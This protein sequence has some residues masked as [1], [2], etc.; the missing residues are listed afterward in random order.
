MNKKAGI[1]NI[2][3]R[4]RKIMRER[5]MQTM[6]LRKK[7]HVLKDWLNHHIAKPYTIVMV[8]DNSERPIQFRLRIGVVTIGMAT[9]VVMLIAL[10]V[11]AYYSSRY[12]QVNAENIELLIN[13]EK[14]KEQ[15]D[16]LKTA[17]EQLKDVLLENGKLREMNDTREKEIKELS[18]IA[19]DTMRQLDEMLLMQNVLREQLGLEAVES[20]G[21]P[22]GVSRNADEPSASQSAERVSLA[23]IAEILQNVREG[24]SYQLDGLSEIE[25]QMDYLNSI[26]ARWPVESRNITSEYG[27]RNNPFGGRSVESHWGIDVGCDW[28]MPIYAAGKGE[29]I[30]AEW[31]SGYGY[32]AVISHGYG[33]TSRYS[34]CSSLLVSEGQHV[35]AGEKIALVGST[36]RSTGPHLDFRIQYNGEYIDP[37][38]ILR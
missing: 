25:G 12:L 8:P 3:Y 19:E 15:L 27:S 20:M 24:V 38:T 5:K 16:T 23:E 34:H 31:E 10:T 29:V 14:Q 17:E 6:P 4:I 13:N 11:F 35:E 32:T 36:G 1:I 9:A 26:P 30:L 18:V 28:G 33:Y 2:E 37:L 22:Q 21:G 7:R